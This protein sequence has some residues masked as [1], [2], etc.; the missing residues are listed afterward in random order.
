MARLESLVSKYRETVTTPW[1]SS[2]AAPQ[3]VIFVI[4]SPLDELR[5]RVQLD[6]F[7]IAT[8]EAGHGWAHEDLTE[9][10]SAW[11][12]EQEYRDSYFKKPEKLMRDANGDLVDFSDALI[13]D[14]RAKVE[15]NCDENTVFSLSGIGSLFGFTHVSRLVESIRDKARGRLLVFFPGDLR[16]NN[17]RL[18]DARD[19]WDYLALAIHAEDY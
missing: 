18:L 14:L 1:V 15:A 8:K 12:T 2:I 11:M 16:D 6:E 3:R 17:Y 9:A 5:L 13:K 7:K 10:F 19:G 4:Y